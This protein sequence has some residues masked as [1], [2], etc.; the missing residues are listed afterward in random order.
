[1]Q[2]DTDRWILAYLG[3]LAWLCA[4][5]FDFLCH[6]RTDLPRTS[7]LTESSLH[8]AQ[9]MLIGAAIMCV[10]AFAPGKALAAIT[11]ALVAAHAVVGYLDTRSAFGRRV[12]LPVEQHLHSV[13]DMA[14][15]IAWIWMTAVAWPAIVQSDWELLLRRPPLEVS[16]WVAVLL[17][18]LL[19]CVWPAALEFRA[20]WAARARSPDHVR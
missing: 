1:M 18:A 17:P 7:G 13:L 16:L 2:I 14:P 5:L 3:Y 10:L 8:W 19:L 9:L 11:F 6:R 12:I 15:V 20:A 4:G